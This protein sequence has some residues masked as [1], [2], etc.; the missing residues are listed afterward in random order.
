MS[1]WEETQLSE[2]AL[3]L[4]SASWRPNTEKTYLSAW[5]RW[6]SWCSTKQTDT[7]AFPSTVTPVIEFLVVEF[8]EGKQDTTLNTY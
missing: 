2:Q 1:Q 4:I 7:C 6:I 5:R 8:Q 3:Q